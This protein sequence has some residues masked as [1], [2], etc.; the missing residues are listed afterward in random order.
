MGGKINNVVICK[1]IGLAYTVRRKISDN[2]LLQAKGSLGPVFT[3]VNGM[4]DRGSG[5]NKAVERDDAHVRLKGV[6]SRGMMFM[7]G[8]LCAVVKPRYTCG[9]RL[10]KRADG[11][12]YV[13]RLGG[14]R[15]KIPEIS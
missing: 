4:M 15:R 9:I 8:V 10:Y 7:F 2:L 6:I 13:T 11:V 12:L 3:V 5:R 14:K 1:N